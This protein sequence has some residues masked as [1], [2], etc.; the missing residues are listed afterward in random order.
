MITCA[1]QVSSQHTSMNRSAKKMLFKIGVTVI[2][3][4]AI[5]MYYAVDKQ[6]TIPT[7]D[8]HKGVLL[9]LYL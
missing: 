9:F 7:D 2:V 1:F 3:L 8:Q 5:Y 6:N 4:V